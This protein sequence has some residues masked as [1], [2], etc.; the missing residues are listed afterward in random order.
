[1][2]AR[3]SRRLF[4]THHRALVIYVRYALL[5][6]LTHRFRTPRITSKIQ[7]DP[8][9]SADSPEARTLSKIE[10]PGTEGNQQDF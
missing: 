3:A 4:P 7:G 5:P 9:R 1:M 8:P 6:H 10:V 2:V